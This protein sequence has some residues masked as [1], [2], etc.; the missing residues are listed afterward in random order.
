MAVELRCDMRLHGVLTDEGV[1]EIACR[2]R[3]CGHRPGVLVIHR[4]D[5]ITGE[6]LG[7]NRYKD[8]SELKGAG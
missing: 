8:A 7:T 5:A 6:L 3:L 2:S 4:F 1:V